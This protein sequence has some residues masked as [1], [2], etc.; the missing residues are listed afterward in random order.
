[1]MLN[2]IEQIIRNGK[3]N[4]AAMTLGSTRKER[5]FTPIISKAS[6]C[7]V[8]L[9]VPISEAIFEPTLPAKIKEIIVGE[10]SRIVLE[11]VIQPIVYLGNSGLSILDAVCNEITAPIKTERMAT[12]PA[13]F[14]DRKSTRLNSS[15]VR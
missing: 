5:E 1:M 13:E 3:K 9:M 12:I 11:R 8:T 7:S 6:I 4:T 14:I 10:N 2:P 15:H